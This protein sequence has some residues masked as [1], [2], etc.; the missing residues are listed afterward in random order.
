MDITYP[1]PHEGVDILALG[2]TVARG[3]TITVDEALGEQL[4]AQGWAPADLPKTAK[5]I[6]AWVDGDPDR[7]R[8]ALDAEQASTKPRKSVLE[9][10][11]ELLDTTPADEA[12]T[13][14]GDL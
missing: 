2:R 1:G 8:I 12:E 3:E 5:A 4:V 7:A 13:P 9:P 10:L 6:V 14:E 11:A